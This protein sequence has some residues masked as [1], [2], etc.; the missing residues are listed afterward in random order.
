MLDVRG[1]SSWHSER[2]HHLRCYVA[3]VAGLTLTLY[4]YVHLDVVHEHRRTCVIPELR[5]L[6]QVL[7]IENPADHLC[8]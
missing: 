4:T 1:F 6:V 8:M 7:Q 2:C 3:A 5:N